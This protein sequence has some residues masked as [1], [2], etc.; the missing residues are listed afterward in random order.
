MDLLFGF[1]DHPGQEIGM[2][3]ALTKHILGAFSVFKTIIA[4]AVNAFEGNRLKP[5]STAYCFTQW[6]QGMV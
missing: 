1:C 2:G 6:K 5:Q 4:M 3:E